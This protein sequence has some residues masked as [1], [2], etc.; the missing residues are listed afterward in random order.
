LLKGD[1]QCFLRQV[2][3]Y[4]YIAHQTGETSNQF[5]R[6]HSPDRINRVVDGGIHLLSISSFF[7]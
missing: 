1:D 5:R 7:P 4:P 3:G 6:F 2:F